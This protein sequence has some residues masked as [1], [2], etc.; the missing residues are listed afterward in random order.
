MK[1]TTKILALQRNLNFLSD[2]R[3]GKDH[4][5]QQ[6]VPMSSRSELEMDSPGWTI[7]SKPRILSCLDE[8]LRRGG[9]AAELDPISVSL[10]VVGTWSSSNNVTVLQLC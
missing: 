2:R 10:Q 1:Q 6:Q 4:N 9:G 3:E 7:N 5:H 8:S